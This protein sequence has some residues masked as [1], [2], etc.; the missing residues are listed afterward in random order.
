MVRESLGRVTALLLLS[1]TGCASTPDVVVRTRVIACPE[2]PPAVTCAY[3]PAE[4]TIVDRVYSADD[5]AA[6]LAD[7]L[8]VWREAWTECAQEEPR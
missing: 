2:Q 1:M 7:A 5:H 3:D 6:C 8:D 4:R